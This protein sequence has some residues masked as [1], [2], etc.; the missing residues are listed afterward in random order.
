[1]PNKKKKLSA[2]QMKIAR[3]APPYDK[4]TG[5]DFKQLKKLKKR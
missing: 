3:L 1:M 2:K 4:M 5:A